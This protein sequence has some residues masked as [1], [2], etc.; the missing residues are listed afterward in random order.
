MKNLTFTTILLMGSI[1]ISVQ[2]E[3]ISKIGS[4]WNVM[5]AED[6]TSYKLTQGY[7]G[8]Y[9]DAEYLLYQFDETTNKLT[10]VSFL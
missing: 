5:S 3:V 7:G 8:Q 2:A 10:M 1:S 4:G 9:F 6:Q